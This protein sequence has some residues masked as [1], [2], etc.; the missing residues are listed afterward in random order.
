MPR[1]RN[2]GHLPED[3]HAGNHHAR[4]RHAEP[5]LPQHLRHLDEEVREFQFFGRSALCHVN[6]EHLGEDSFGDICGP[7]LAYI[8][9]KVSKDKEENSRYHPGGSLRS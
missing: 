5:E 2:G 7:L 8:L 6:F 4:E 1:E 3:I 9:F